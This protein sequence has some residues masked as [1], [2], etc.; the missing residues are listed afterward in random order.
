MR[1]IKVSGH[2]VDDAAYLGALA[3][4]V[5]EI[6]AQER[7]VVVNGGGKGIRALQGAFGLPERKVAGLRVTDARSLDLT[8]MVMSAQVNKRI[9]R[10]LRQVGLD[11]LG[12]SG[13]DAGL[14]TAQKKVV[15]GVDLGFVGEIVAVRSDLIHQFLQMGLLPVISPVSCDVSGQHYN[16]NGDEAATAVAQALAAEQLDFVSNVP[17][18]LPHPEASEPL[19]RLTAVAVRDL[20]ARGIIWGGMVPKVTAV[21]EAISH[22]VK[23]ARIVD[24]AGL[25]RGGTVF[26]NE[27]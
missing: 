8:E 22:G 7:M 3:T 18:V 2:Q 23:R 1:V 12:M 25:V 4:A 9:V 26:T 10:A 14:L 21:L 27:Q 19:A 17:G 16:V 24:L 15:D 13:V 20:L 11:A 5:A 6:A